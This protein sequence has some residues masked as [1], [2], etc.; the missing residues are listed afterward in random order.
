MKILV[1]TVDGKEMIDLL[2]MLAD[3]RTLIMEGHNEGR[4][5]LEDGSYNFLIRDN[6]ETEK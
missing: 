3:V 5:T 1:L 4:A 2:N 6:E